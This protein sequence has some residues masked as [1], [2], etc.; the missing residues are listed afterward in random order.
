MIDI[1]L[2]R[3]RTLIRPCADGETGAALKRAGLV[4]PATLTD[5]PRKRENQNSL[6]RGVVVA[7]GAPA[8]ARKGGAEVAPGHA[9][10]DDV[11]F[12]GQGRARVVEFDGE[13]LRACAHEEVVAVISGGAT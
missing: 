11:F 8:L 6:G 1:R 2:L 13:L 4:A 5:D 9:I 7:M 10:G 3:G 12:I